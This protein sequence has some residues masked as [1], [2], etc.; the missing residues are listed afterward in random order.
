MT[1]L[2]LL[3]MRRF[4]PDTEKEGQL[5]SRAEKMRIAAAIEQVIREID[6]PEVNPDNI[7]FN[8]HVWGRESWSFAAI[9]P[10]RAADIGTVDPNPWNERS[11]TVTHACPECGLVHLPK[12][13][14][15]AVGEGIS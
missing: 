7:Q 12:M 1:R 15:T 11:R 5:F 2:T 3:R 10:N 9:R 8:L 13:T 4:G 6:H 14:A